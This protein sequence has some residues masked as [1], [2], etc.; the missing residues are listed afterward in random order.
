MSGVLGW[1]GRLRA[2]SQSA[3]LAIALLL[4]ANLIPLFGVLFLGWS[5]AMVL[6]AYWLENGVVG[7]LNVPKVL[8]AGRS[9]AGG[10][11]SDMAGAT[12]RAVFF[13]FHYGVFWV[14]HGV[15]VF[16]LTGAAAPFSFFFG[17]GR[18]GAAL[19]PAA[20][21]LVALVLLASH[22]ASFVFN[23]VGK[24]EY[25]TTT[26]ERQSFQPYGRLVVLH[27][28]IV[29]G[30][31]FILGLGSPVALVALLVVLKTGVDLLLH[32]REHRPGSG[33]VT[34]V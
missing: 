19:D 22:G 27:V 12:V 14:V 16:F 13:G 29:F 26:P 23:Y 33:Q 3:P 17:F 34:V 15:F 7:L 25:L 10:G 21:A 6:I 18:G 5:V 20:L 30:G 31:I 28:T 8:L 1:L 9:A 2:T 11:G 4:I 24:R 32:L